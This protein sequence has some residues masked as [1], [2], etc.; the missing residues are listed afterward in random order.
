MSGS[1]QNDSQ[2]GVKG[3]KRHFSNEP[4][5]LLNNSGP[6]VDSLETSK[7]QSGTGQGGMIHILRE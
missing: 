2:K 4:E 3:D 6:I 7:R 1:R 5:I